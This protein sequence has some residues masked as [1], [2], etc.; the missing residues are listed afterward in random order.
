ML[1]R[2]GKRVCAFFFVITIL[3]MGSGLYIGNIAYE[4]FLSA[5][6]NQILGVENHTQDIRPIQ[7]AERRFGWRKTYVVAS[8]GTL[9]RGTYI[10]AERNSHRTVILLHGLYQNRSMC[11]PYAE[12]YH[13]LG[14]NVLL[15]DLRGHGESGGMHTEWGIREVGDIEAWVQWLR[16]EDQLSIIGL[17]GISLGGAMALLYAGSEQGSQLAFCVSDS[18]YG[19]ILQLGKDKAFDWLQDPKAIWGVNIVAPFFQAAMFYHTHQFLSDIEPLRA[20]THITV[21]VLILHGSADELIPAAT[22]ED[23]YQMCRS[24]SK[25]IYIFKKAPHAVAIEKNYNEYRRV[26]TDFLEQK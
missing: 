20:V 11:L 2:F 6:W 1:R 19:N 18:S 12:I 24:N 7:R 15:V 17:H 26:L 16:K 5:H 22:A 21:P 25:Y 8:D 10:E 4:H 23:L 14:Y 9:L 3:F 13:N